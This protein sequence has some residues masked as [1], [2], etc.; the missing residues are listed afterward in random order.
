MI[1]RE[2]A[3]DIGDD[4]HDVAVTLH[5]HEIGERDTTEFRNP[6]NIVAGEIDKHEMFR[7]LLG[8]GKQLTR[9]FRIRLRRRPSLAGAG[10]GT[11][12]DIS[13][14]HLHM[15]LRRASDQGDPSRKTQAEHVWRGIH[16]A[17][18][19]VEMHRIARIR[20]RTTLGE[21]DL[22][23]IAGLDELLRIKHGL[24][25]G[26]S[27]EIALNGQLIGLA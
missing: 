24:L 12:L 4:V 8:I 21:D 9:E 25:K 13:F 19:A 10:N 2:S 15:N 1:T 7:A 22:E 16:E 27:G 3:R 17:Q 14:G 18:G 6:P 11:D 26:P 23:D 5:G 20:D